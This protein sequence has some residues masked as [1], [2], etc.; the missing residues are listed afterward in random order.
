MQQILTKLAQ[1]HAAH[2]LQEISADTSLS[3]LA[4]RLA[5]NGILVIAGELPESD[6]ENR[7]AEWVGA[8][9]DLYRNLTRALFP[10]FTALDA[11]YA[12]HQKP[13]IVVLKGEC[14]P[15]I[16]ALG[17]YVAPYVALREQDE[18][19]SEAELRGVMTFILDDLEATDLA[20]EMYT[21][22]WQ[23]G[24][25]II[26]R[27]LQMP[28]SHYAVTSFSRPLF[29][30]LQQEEAQAKSLPGQS[31][32]TQED[33]NPPELLP[34]HPQQSAEIDP[35]TLFKSKIPIFFSGKSS[36]RGRRPPV[37]LPP[38]LDQD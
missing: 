17:R 1:Q 35:A 26:Q 34:D 36:R 16:Q 25:Q 20:N 14:G 5:K 24:A 30:K 12:D 8:Y 2:L 6:Y 10:S 28:V 19:V 15:V 37:P 31:E 9:G 21:M 22:L 11:V 29:Q 33:P 23:D 18:L 27:L 32:T 7:V 13:P 3:W 38:D 4:D